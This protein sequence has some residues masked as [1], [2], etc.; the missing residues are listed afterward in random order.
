MVEENTGVLIDG[1]RKPRLTE[2]NLAKTAEDE[3]K[4][5]VLKEGDANHLFIWRLKFLAGQ[6]EPDQL[7]CQTQ[8]EIKNWTT[9]A[10]TFIYI[11]M[12]MFY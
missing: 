4:T 10:T 12:M 9:A 7:C 8:I 2:E 11:D 6:C 3:R 5:V 1:T